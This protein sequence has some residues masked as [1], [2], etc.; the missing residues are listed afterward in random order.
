MFGFTVEI[1]TRAEVVNNHLRVMDVLDRQ[2]A[3]VIQ[4]INTAPN[5]SLFAELDLIGRLR[6]EEMVAPLGKRRTVFWGE[7]RIIELPF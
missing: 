6:M 3:R 1:E 5:E 4:R 2:R 7:R